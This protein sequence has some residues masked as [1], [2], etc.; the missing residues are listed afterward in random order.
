[1]LPNPWAA[2]GSDSRIVLNLQLQQDQSDPLELPGKTAIC[3]HSL[4]VKEEF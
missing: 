2:Y 3:A 1:M 4:G